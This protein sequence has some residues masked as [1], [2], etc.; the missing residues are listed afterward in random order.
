MAGSARAALLG[1]RPALVTPA[2][3]AAQAAAVDRRG[4]HAVAASGT[5]GADSV[6]GVVHQRLQA[7]VRRPQVHDTHADGERQFDRV[8][9]RAVQEGLLTAVRAGFARL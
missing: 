9:R 5:R 6:F 2:A 1:A 8:F 4:A 7:L 3:Q